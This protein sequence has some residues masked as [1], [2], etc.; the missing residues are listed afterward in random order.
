[1]KFLSASSAREDDALLDNAADNIK[2]SI[3]VLREGGRRDDIEVIPQGGYIS[4]RV[5]REGGRLDGK[6]KFAQKDISI[7][8]LREG[9]RPRSQCPCRRGYRISIRVLR[10]GGRRDALDL[11]VQ[12]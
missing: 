11:I 12:P 1:M 3:R 8:V 9:G 4:I 7:R 6:S 5:L 10:E 2:I